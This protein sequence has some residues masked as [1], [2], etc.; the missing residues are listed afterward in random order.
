M[1]KAPFNRKHRSEFCLRKP[2]H[3]GLTERN[4]LTN[5]G[6][7]L[8]HVFQQLIK[9]TSKLVGAELIIGQQFMQISFM[10]NQIK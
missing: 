2:E 7:W 6:K 1:S 5:P 10:R 9:V 8:I 3:S 4:W